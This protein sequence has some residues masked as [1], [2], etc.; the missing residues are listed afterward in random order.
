MFKYKNLE[1][2]LAE[3]RELKATTIPVAIGALGLIKEGM[4]KCTEKIPGD[5]KN[6]ELQ[7]VT[8]IG[9]SYM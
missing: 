2:E 3:M 1:I 8:L 9:M 5:V 7:Q 6:Q 4:V